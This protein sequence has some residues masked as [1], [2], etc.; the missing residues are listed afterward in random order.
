MT[1]RMVQRHELHDST[2]DNIETTFRHPHAVPRLKAVSH[3]LANIQSLYDQKD[4]DAE[5]VEGRP[6]I[7]G[8]PVPSARQGHSAGR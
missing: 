1:A 6:P 5:S 7:V 4:Q 3:N 8:A 2:T